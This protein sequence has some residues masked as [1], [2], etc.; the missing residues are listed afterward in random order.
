MRIFIIGLFTKAADVDSNASSPS[1][2]RCLPDT[3]A[4]LKLPNIIVILKVQ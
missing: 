3:G 1:A 4:S 2:R